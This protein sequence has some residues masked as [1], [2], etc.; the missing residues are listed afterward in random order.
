[1]GGEEKPV[2]AVEVGLRVPHAVLRGG[3]GR[4]RAFVTAV[5]EADIDRVWVG[6][7]V[8]FKGGQG[9]DGLLQAA[10]IAAVSERVMVQT[11]VYLLPLRHPLTVARQVANLT[12]LAPGRFTFGVGV[13]GDDPSE[14]WN[15]GVDPASRGARTDE[16]LELVRRLISGEVVTAEGSH[17]TL[18]SA[19]ILP[20]PDPPVAIVVGGRSAAALRRAGRLGDGWLGVF[21]SPSRF[22]EAIEAVDS[23]AA[24]AGRTGVDQ[25][26]ILAWCGFGRSPAAEMEALY[27]Q[28]FRAFERYAPHGTAEVV[29]DSLRPYVEAGATSVLLAGAADDDDRLIEGARLVRAL[30]RD[31]ADTTPSPDRR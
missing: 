10:A 7:H 11:A 9:Y 30:L 26:G 20:A 25:H 2:V 4:L 21:V 31:A 28:P 8:S 27:Q 1:M 18:H 24:A 19:S 12:E 6:D 17:F 23:A 3:A 22:A 15:C 13:G 14:V 16:S 5:E 29:A